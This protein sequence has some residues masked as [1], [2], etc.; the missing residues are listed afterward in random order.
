VLD[1]VI[2]D[3]NARIGE[4]A[5]LVNE[6]GIEEADGDGYFIRNGIVI[7]PKDGVIPAGTKV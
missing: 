2:V 3:K 5:Q 4:G 6:S 1:R 7:V